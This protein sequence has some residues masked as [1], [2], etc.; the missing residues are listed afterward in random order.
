MFTSYLH[1]QFLSKGDPN[2]PITILTL[3]A[4]STI[5][6][7]IIHAAIILDALGLDIR[8]LESRPLYE[9][10]SFAS[11]LLSQFQSHLKT[12]PVK[13]TLYPDAAAALASSGVDVL[14]LGADR[15]AASGAV[16]NKTGSLPASLSVR[17]I[18]PAAKVVVLSELEKVADRPDRPS[19]GG[20][21]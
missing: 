14:L 8:L 6:E 13:I 12:S 9:G 21:E 4:S 5:R 3:S 20:R 11:T 7:C 10:V 2:S 15:I 16:S 17:H 19:C 1:N 18:S